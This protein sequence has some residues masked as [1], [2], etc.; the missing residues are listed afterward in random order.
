MGRTHNMTDYD[1]TYEEFKWEVPEYFNF[2]G[3]VIDIRAQDPDKLAMVWV[4]DAGTEVRKT[5][6]ELS[7]ASK[8]L[9]NFLTSTGVSK[10][11]VVM[12]VLPSNVEWWEAFTACIRMGALIAPGTTQLTS[13]DLEYRINASEAVCII[14]NNEIAAKFDEITDQCPSV[15]SRIVITEPRDGWLFYTDEVNNA[16]EDFETA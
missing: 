2:A 14:T 15:K 1:K 8:K 16:S 3:E 7:N 13:K 12:V 5:F 9:A 10:G 6:L 4:D 11:D